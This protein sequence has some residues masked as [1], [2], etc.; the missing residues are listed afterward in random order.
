M[1]AVAG[2]EDQAESVTWWREVVRAAGIKYQHAK[3]K[4]NRGDA[5]ASVKRHARSFLG[6]RQSSD[7]LDMGNSEALGAAKAS[8]TSG[9]YERLQTVGGYGGVWGGVWLAV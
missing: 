5:V 4:L 3:P 8:A 7:C 9:G 2:V 6:F 1:C